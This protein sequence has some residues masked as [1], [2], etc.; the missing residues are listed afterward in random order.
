M[1][2][3][4]QEILRRIQEFASAS[5]V[6]EQTARQAAEATAGEIDRLVTNQSE[7][8]RELA[9]LYLPRLDDDV[10]RD[11]WSEMRSTLQTII[12]RKE[13]A[14]RVCS[15]RLRQASENRVQ[16]DERWKGLC[17]R[18]NELTSRC[19]ELA[20]QFA[21]QLA[22]DIEFQTLSRRAAE[23]QARLEQAQANL[24]QVDNDAKAKLPS[25]NQSRLFQYLWQSQ[26]GTERY[27]RRGLTRRLDRWLSQMIGFPQAAAGYRFL[28][29]A[30]EQMRQ[31]IHEQQKSVSSIMEE[32]EARQANAAAVLGLPA[33]QEDGRKVRA[34]YES[35]GIAAENARRAEEI[36]RQQ[37][38]ELASPDCQYYRDALTAFQNLI[39][40]TE[41]SLVAARAA[42]T[43]ELT[44]D[45]VVARLKHI[46]EQVAEKKQQLDRFFHSAEQAAKRTARIHELASKC[47][48]AQFD[49]PR[50]VFDDDFDLQAQLDA[51]IAGTLDADTAYQNMYRRQ[52]LDSPV[53]DQAAAALQGPMAQ[54]L[55]QTM[56]Q[57]A[58]AALGS[59]A[60][61]AGQQ[62]R[63]RGQTKD[64]F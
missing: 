62:H 32:V 45:Q 33:I 20:A 55:L 40:R 48:R 30:P 16:L 36:A 42:H 7:S 24:Q 22:E 47:R 38:T 27:V 8:F 37:L 34:E 9:Q 56:A 53:A 63:V 60:A 21:R 14:H 39:E 29:T 41:R 2:V 46:D 64:W 50:R 52:H 25:Y 43:P 28:S 54:V 31:L 23:G 58:G 49:H 18:L 1:P 11:G 61:R 15:E 19:D 59:Y 3:P 35:A 51:L 12:L 17:D 6:V 10:E 44:D 4:G 5:G 26:F 57:A 13:D